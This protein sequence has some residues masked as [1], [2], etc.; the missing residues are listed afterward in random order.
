M[1][2]LCTNNQDLTVYPIEFGSLPL[3]RYPLYEFGILLKSPRLGRGGSEGVR[4]ERGHHQ[5][6]ES[7]L[8]CGVIS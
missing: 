6:N 8:S 7:G 1:Y 5:A 4:L 3:G 2:R